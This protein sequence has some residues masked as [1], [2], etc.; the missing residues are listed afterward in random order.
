MITRGVMKPKFVQSHLRSVVGCLAILGLTA[1]GYGSYTRL[2]AGMGTP[3]GLNALF[4]ED[5]PNSEAFPFGQILKDVIDHYKVGEVYKNAFDRLLDEKSGSRKIYTTEVYAKLLALRETHEAFSS[6]ATRTLRTEVETRL[7]SDPLRDEY[8]LILEVLQEKKSDISKMIRKDSEAASAE[9]AL[10][11]IDDELD[12]RIRIIRQC[13]RKERGLFPGLFNLTE[14][15]DLNFQEKATH[16]RELVKKAVTHEGL[17]SSISVSSGALNEKP[18]I[19]SW[20]QKQAEMKEVFG[21]FRTPNQTRAPLVI[22]PSVGKEGNMTG[23]NF[24]QGTFALT[25]D[26]GPGKTT[27]AILDHLKAHELKATFFVLSQQVLDNKYPKTALRTQAEGHALASHSYTHANMPKITSAAQDHELQDAAAVFKDR[28]GVS[29]KYYRLP[30]GAGVSISSIRQKIAKL[31]M[32][33][34]FWTVDTLDWQDKDP[35]SIFIRTKKQMD[36]YGR[37]IILFHD[38]H[39]QSV[40]ASEKVMNELKLPE[41]RFRSVTIPEIVDELNGISPQVPIPAEPSPAPTSGLNSGP[42][43]RPIFPVP[44][45]STSTH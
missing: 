21:T 3:C 6:R 30:Y 43:W 23:L 27:A 12:D 42:I 5:H 45:P 7:E 26:D 41:N 16:R 22:F 35:D 14:E 18:F 2:P 13:I 19:Q 44:V 33:H 17:G 28:F 38:I 1:F 10:S 39:A 36:Q 20:E 37:G 9:L 15:S 4:E 11:G 40:I 25:F 31:G 32:V 29:P 8:E 24:P 34:V